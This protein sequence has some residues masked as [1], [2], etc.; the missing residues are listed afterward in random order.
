MMVK[1]RLLDGF[2]QKHSWLWMTKGRVTDALCACS[3]L[4]PA[5]LQFYLILQ[6]FPCL[7]VLIELTLWHL[8]ALCLF[9]PFPISFAF[10]AYLSIFVA[11]HI[12]ELKWILRRVLYC[13][14]THTHTLALPSLL[15][16][17]FFCSCWCVRACVWLKS[18]PGEV[19]NACVKST[20]G[21]W[22]IGRL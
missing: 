21:L 8:C 6:V 1:T 13:S 22:R 7:I 16:F 15:F 20:W 18:C 3:C 9:I 17:F 2:N 11:R 19:F 10:S 4:Y 12:R 5:V 14:N